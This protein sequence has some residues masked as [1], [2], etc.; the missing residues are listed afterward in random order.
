M[1]SAT[2]L[3]GNANVVHEAV[4]ERQFIRTKIPARVTLSA[5]NSSLECELLDIS[6]GGIGIRCDRQ[7]PIGGLF[8]AAL[9]LNLNG[10]DLTIDSKIKVLTQR[11]RDVGAEFVDLD[12]KK[13][14]ILRYLM[15]AYMS[16][17][18]ADINGLMNVMQRENYI[19]ARKKPAELKRGPGERVRALLGTLAFLV[20]GL[21]ALAFVVYKTHQMLFRVPATQA[22]VSA[23]S[24]RLNMPANGYV[25]YTLAPDQTEVGAGDPVATVS[26][27]LASTLNTPSDVGALANLSQADLQTILGRSLIETVIASPCDCYVFFP[28]KRLDA[29]ALKDQPLVHLIPK[30]EPMYIKA[31]FPF[32]AIEDLDNI[33][34]VELS[35]AG[36]DERFNGQIVRSSVDEQNHLLVLTIRPDRE[37]PLSAYNKPAA[38]ELYRGLPFG[39]SSG[40]SL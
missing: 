40:T 30:G 16:G 17:E 28:E 36:S 26:T 19:K 4:D 33:R 15:T 13:R 34:S 12:S 7:L 5:N 3:P 29:Y 1:T 37:L 39:R 35:V 2:V 22:L 18:I 14:D 10:V 25:K 8:N 23:D 38:V 20:L 11:G 31:S 21:I 32:G 24:Y 27:Q 6:L 9:H